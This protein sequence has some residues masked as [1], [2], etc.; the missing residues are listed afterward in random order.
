MPE[1]RVV[2]A[3]PPGLL[4][5]RQQVPPTGLWLKQ[6]Q[7]AL[8][9]RIALLEEGTRLIII[10]RTQPQQLRLTVTRIA[11]DV[12]RAVAHG[13]PRVLVEIR[14]VGAAHGPRQSRNQQHEQQW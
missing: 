1:L 6:Q 8:L 2:L 13:L 9:G 11:T 5:E 3:G 7:L 12:A 4:V 14:D 10:T